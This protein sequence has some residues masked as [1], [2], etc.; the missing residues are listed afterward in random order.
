[1]NL[2]TK[3]RLLAHVARWVLTWKRRD[4]GYRAPGLTDPRFMTAREAAALVPDG[5]T[6]AGAGMAG[7]QRASILYWAIAERFQREGRPRG[8][9]WIS[10][11]AQ[12]GRAKV[13]GTME[14]LGH[15]GLITRYVAGHLETL[16]A[17]LALGD[18]GKVE[19]HTL[20]QGEMCFLLEAQGRGEA[21]LLSTTGLGTFLDPATGRGSPVTPGAAENLVS[22]EGDRLRYRLPRV[23]LALFAMP[24]ADRDGNLYATGAAV[25]TEAREAALAARRNGG[26]VI[27]CV[28]GVVERDDAAIFLPASAVDAI[29]VNP[30]NEQTCSVPQ[31]EAWPM[32]TA[33]AQVDVVE[34]VHQLKFI[35][36][37]LKI[38]PVRKEAEDALARL[39]ASRVARELRP[40]AFVNIGVGM[41]EEVSRLFFEAGLHRDLTFF[42]ETGLVGGLPAPGIFFG[43][44]I[45][46]R[47]MLGS[48]AVFH[49]CQERLD[50]T[51]LGQLQVDSAGNVNVSKRGEGCRNYV[52]PGGL[53]TMVDAARA[54]FIVGAWKVG[55]VP[56]FVE[57][58][59]EVTFNGQQALRAGKPVFYVTTVGVFRLTARGMELCEVM[60]GLDVRRDVV[61]ATPMKVVLPEDGRVPVVEAAVASGQGFALG[62]S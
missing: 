21:S 8:L 51:V 3:A 36:T 14:E 34:A 10:V 28:A 4:T 32:F 41:P 55:D 38:T 62:W 2:L 48:A 56:R 24:W 11:G 20:P 46:P 15:A 58:V 6:V 26:K 52:G 22:R 29:V 7:A 5:A 30:R 44:A 45:N 40:G 23:D 16:K 18:E 43:S 25:V 1:M 17:F 49:R 13:P 59:D 9:T 42:I 50:V 31:R 53:P 19:L 33:G 35:N 12:G 57:R 47:E 27:A 54:I 39:A 37:T 60:P 61:E